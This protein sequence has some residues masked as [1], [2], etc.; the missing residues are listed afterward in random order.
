MSSRDR[1]GPAAPEPRRRPAAAGPSGSRHP[2][3]SRAP[4]RGRSATGLGM[5]RVRIARARRRCPGRGRTPAR[6]WRR[7]PRRL[8]VRSGREH[9]GSRRRGDARS[10]CALEPAGERP[11]ERRRAERLREERERPT[12]SR[13]QERSRLPYTGPTAAGSECGRGRSADAPLPWAWRPRRLPPSQHRPR[14]PRGS[15]SASELGADSPGIVSPGIATH[16]SPAYGGT[17]SSRARSSHSPQAI[18][19]GQPGPPRGTVRLTRLRATRPD[20]ADDR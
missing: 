9:G 15:T 5:F 1:D 18:G 10:G 3:G 7:W 2:A 17:W 19:S 14:V 13:R 4:A 6:R 8:P 20:R 12:V 16:S 11:L